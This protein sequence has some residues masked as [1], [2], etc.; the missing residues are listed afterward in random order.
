MSGTSWKSVG[1][2][3]VEQRSREGSGMLAFG[4]GIKRR[5]RNPVTAVRFELMEGSG[6][7]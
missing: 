3:H 5:L 2:K 6:E 1:K 4:I 7:R